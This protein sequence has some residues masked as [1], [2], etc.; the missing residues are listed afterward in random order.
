MIVAYH[1][2]YQDHVSGKQP[3]LF[4]GRNVDFLLTMRTSDFE[5]RYVDGKAEVCLSRNMTPDEVLELGEALVAAATGV[6]PTTE[7][8]IEEGIEPVRKDVRR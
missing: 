8:I 7:V 6:R 5:V 4:V 3:R 1:S 2:V